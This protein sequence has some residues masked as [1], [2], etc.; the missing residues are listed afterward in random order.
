MPLA[1]ALRKPLGAFL[2][3]VR[4]MSLPDSRPDAGSQAR[5]TD[6]NS[7]TRTHCRLCAPK[8]NAQRYYA[9]PDNRERML[10]Y[11]K[12]YRVKQRERRLQNGNPVSESC[13]K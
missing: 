7:P 3:E 1:E 5:G 9:K 6:M 12:E 11:Q 8:A 4:Y 2:L 10:Q 13:V